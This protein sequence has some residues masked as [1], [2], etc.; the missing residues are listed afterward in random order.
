MRLL[1]ELKKLGNFAWAARQKYGEFLG[2]LVVLP[3]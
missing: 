2:L 1:Q 3:D